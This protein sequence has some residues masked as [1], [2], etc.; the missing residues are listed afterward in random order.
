MLKN[1]EKEISLKNFNFY[2]WKKSVAL[3]FFNVSTSKTKT[4]TSATKFF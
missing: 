2:S 3:D 1:I 4:T